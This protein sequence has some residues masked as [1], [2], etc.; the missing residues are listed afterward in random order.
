[1]KR[2]LEIFPSYQ[3]QTLIESKK[4]KSEEPTPAKVQKVCR[5]AE[6][7]LS[8]MPAQQKPSCYFE[9][10]PEELQLQILSFLPLED[11]QTTQNVNKTLNRLSDEK[12]I[13]LVNTKKIPLAELGYSYTQLQ[14]LVASSGDRID[15]LNLSNS[16]ELNKL[17]FIKYCQ[18]ITHLILRKCYINSEG[19]RIFATLKCFSNLTVLDISDNSLHNIGVEHLS[20]SPSLSQVTSLNLS[21]TEID[22]RGAEF[23]AQTT[24][25]NALRILDVSSNRI[26]YVGA[27]KILDSKNLTS[28]TEINLFGNPITDFGGHYIANVIGLSKITS[29]NLAFTQISE[30]GLQAMI[31]SKYARKITRLTYQTHCNPH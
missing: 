5:Q 11:L 6:S 21:K 29:L 25:L 30:I 9:K 26:D 28:L 13:E 12:I 16:G 3:P 10:L 15:F 23:I 1:M 18:N 8:A 24:Y 20:K 19:A 31:C 22:N 17:K 14:T 4:R 27:G 2:N 7:I